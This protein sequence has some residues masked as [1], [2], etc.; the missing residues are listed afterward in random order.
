[1]KKKDESKAIGGRAR[2]ASL[3]PEKKKEIAMKAAAAR[4]G[5]L[6][7]ATHKGNFKDEFGIDVD[8][9]V[10]DDPKKTAVISQRGMG[11]IL[12]LA[13]SGG[14][15]TRFAFS[16]GMAGA[17]GAHLAAKMKKPLK[18]QWSVGGG[19]K[20]LRTAVSGYDVTLLIDVC[21]A[22]I[23]AEEADEL[24]YQQRPIAK[25]AHLILNSSAKVGIENLVYS[26]AGYDI[27]KEEVIAA[28]K[29][30]VRE[31]ARDYERE[32]PPELYEEWYRLYRLPKPERNKPWKFMHL[33]IDQVYR[34]LA[35]SNG[36]VHQLV[37][38]QR[39][40]KNERG[41][42]LHQFLSEIGVKALRLHL[43]K[44]VGIAQTSNGQMEYERHVERIFGAQ[45]QLDLDGPDGPATA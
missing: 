24:H 6:P 4:W 30:Y 18:F 45:Q 12:G 40:S 27:A 9:Y 21:R 32:F 31:E 29:M 34:P 28:F 17:V 7:K 36:R 35:K 15:F 14:A 44:L 43:G 5:I 20:G 42:K 8:C 38:A 23:K 1:M 11:L 10:L 22:V 37:V 2:A 39:A 19:Q 33:T 41:K 13:P 16:K 26:L 25:Q 3:T